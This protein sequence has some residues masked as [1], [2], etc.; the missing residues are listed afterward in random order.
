VEAKVEEPLSR[1]SWPLE[2]LGTVAS[3]A[4]GGEPWSLEGT[5]GLGRA[6]GATGWSLG[7]WVG[8][9]GRTAG[10][11]LELGERLSERLRV[12]EPSRVG[13][14]ASGGPAV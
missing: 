6:A 2:V 4:I 1:E 7:P 5:V 14:T 9:L 12:V 3:R 13:R 11:R 8:V 10:E